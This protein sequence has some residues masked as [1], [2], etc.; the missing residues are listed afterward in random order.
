MNSH[1]HQG[2]TVHWLP[3][4]AKGL[5]AP[6]ECDVDDYFVVTNDSTSGMRSTFRGRCL[7]GIEVETGEFKWYVTHARKTEFP[8]YAED[9]Q[10]PAHVEK[11]VVWN[12][13]DL[14][15]KSDVVQQAVNLARVQHFLGSQ[16]GIE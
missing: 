9:V 2:R 6:T 1:E 13:D 14:P 15:L 11:L 16:S 10:G 3:F 12:H 4:A 8:S 7:R 5:S